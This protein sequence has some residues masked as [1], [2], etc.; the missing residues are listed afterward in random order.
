M[1]YESLAKP[2]LF[3]LDAET[4]H[5]EVSGLMSL[6]APLCTVTMSAPASMNR[7]AQKSGSETFKWMSS[8]VVVRARRAA[9]RSGPKS[10]SGTL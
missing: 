1:L 5:E 8:K 3:S 2:L 6:L 4:A 7:G 9:T 10:S